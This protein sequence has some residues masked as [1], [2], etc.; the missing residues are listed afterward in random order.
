M[1]LEESTTEFCNENEVTKC[2]ISN[3]QSEFQVCSIYSF[4]SNIDLHEA[5]IITEI[6]LQIHSK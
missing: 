4:L 2:T 5:R 1:N 3:E 6:F